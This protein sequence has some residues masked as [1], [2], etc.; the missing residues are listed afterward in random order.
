MIPEGARILQRHANKL[1]TPGSF[2]VVSLATPTDR[3]ALMGLHAM[4]SGHL[5]YHI[6][7][8]ATAKG[9]DSG[10]LMH[11]KLFFARSGQTAWLWT[12]SHNLTKMATCGA[13]C[14]AAVL[15][16][17][18]YREPPF[19]EA[20]KHMEICRSESRLFPP[21]DP[22]SIQAASPT[23]KKEL[24]V[25]AEAEDPYLDLTGNLIELRLQRANQAALFHIHRS[26]YLYLYSH[27]S[28]Q[29]GIP[30]PNRSPKTA[31]RGSILGVNKAD[32]QQIVWQDVSFVVEKAGT[33]FRLTD[34]RE[35]S[36]APTV[37]QCLFNLTADLTEP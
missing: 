21:P 4:V 24:A 36:R 20:L 13:N 9:R 22:P 1:S 32:S 12:G 31:Y 28:L 7:K 33:C 14:E 8:P 26:I 2:A 29:N 16:E 19:I 30:Q 5:Y 35:C 34:P 27:G 3:L 25:H 15:L 10:P 23:R 17:G 18:D 37:T 6:A 11:S